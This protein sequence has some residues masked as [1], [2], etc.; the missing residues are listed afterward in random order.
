MPAPLTLTKAQAQASPYFWT[1]SARGARVVV[2]KRMKESFFTL[3]G[4]DD[5]EAVRKINAHE[6][7]LAADSKAVHG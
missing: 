6:G 4:A 5:T 3:E 2:A 1:W 7:W